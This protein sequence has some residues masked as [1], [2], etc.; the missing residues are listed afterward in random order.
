MSVKAPVCMHAVGVGGLSLPFAG[1]AAR[2][3]DVMGQFD[4][5]S[6]LGLHD[7]PRW[8]RTFFLQPPLVSLTFTPTGCMQRLQ[9]QWAAESFFRP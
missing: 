1:P 3:V 2:F 8:I 6:P 4:L 5:Q 7:C 9:E